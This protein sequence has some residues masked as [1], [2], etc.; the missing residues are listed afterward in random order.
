MTNNEDDQPTDDLSRFEGLALEDAIDLLKAYM[1]RRVDFLDTGV[2]LYCHP[3]SGQVFLMDENSNI[4]VYDHGELRQWATCRICGAEGFID[5][6][7][8]GFVD[9]SICE[10]CAGER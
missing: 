6:D 4:G 8:P 5:A 7:A 10:K 2:R 1:F 3:A 9:D